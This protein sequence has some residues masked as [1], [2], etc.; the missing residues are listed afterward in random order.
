MSSPQWSFKAIRQ[1]SHHN[2]FHYLMGKYFLPI[3]WNYRQ[4]SLECILTLVLFPAF[5][6]RWK[7]SEFTLSLMCFQDPALSLFSGS[8]S[9]CLSWGGSQGWD[10]CFQAF[11]SLH[12]PGTLYTPLFIFPYKNLQLILNF[13]MD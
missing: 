9:H 1:E 4:I 3:S 11:L 7:H 6:S 5:H 10:F 2:D 13:I 12:L 8:D